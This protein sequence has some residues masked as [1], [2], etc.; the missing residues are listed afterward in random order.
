MCTHVYMSVPANEVG[1]T[2]NHHCNCE[3][4]S[5]S[6]DYPI[7][8]RV[9]PSARKVRVHLGSNF[10][11]IHSNFLS[12]RIENLQKSSFRSVA[13][14][15]CSILYVV[16]ACTHWS[17]IHACTHFIPVWS[18]AVVPL[19][20]DLN[21][22]TVPTLGSHYHWSVTLAT[23]KKTKLTLLPKH[24]Y[25]AWLQDRACCN[26]TTEARCTCIRCSYDS[27]SGWGPHS[28]CS[29]PASCS[30]ILWDLLESSELP[31]VYATQLAPA[32]T[33]DGVYVYLCVYM[34]TYRSREVN[35][36]LEVVYQI[37]H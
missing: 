29:T 5:A 11:C 31:K 23:H 35:G 2:C 36:C 3:L 34:H 6:I 14:Y 4:I 16:Y 13:M 37:S 33:V 19:Y 27:V 7:S 22:L 12:Q 9:V 20:E 15:V 25:V 1:I 30:P 18:R 8:V 10:L 21:Q 32:Y 24:Q 26:Y 17:C 28:H